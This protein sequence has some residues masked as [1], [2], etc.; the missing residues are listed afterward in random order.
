[1]NGFRVLGPVEALID[2]RRL[3]LGGPRQVA[4]LALLLL[5]ANRAV[6]ADVLI[7]ALWGCERDGAM[8]RLQMAIARLRKALEPL[9][10]DDGSVL[11]TVT[12]GYML[13]VAPGELD[14][15]VFADRVRDG[16]RALAEGNPGRASELLEEAL[17][18]WRGR[19][20]PEVAFEDFAQ[21]DIRRLEELRLSALETRID[22]DLRLGRHGELIAELE[23]LLDQDPTRE[24]LAGQL[25]TALY[26]SGRQADAL[27][28]FQRTR[29][30]LA[31]ELGLEPGPSLKAVQQQVL[32][33]DPALSYPGASGSAARSSD[34]EPSGSPDRS[35]PPLESLNRSNLPAPTSPLVGRAEELSLALELLAAPEVRLLTLWG[36]GGSGKTRLALEVAASAAARYRDGVRIVMLA[37]IADRALMVSE[38]ARVL[39]I[40]PV[41][42]ESLERTL[43]SGLS[44]RELLL[45][46]DNFEHLLAG[47][48]VVAELLANAPSVAVLATSREPLRIRGEHRMDVPPLP[49]DEAAELFLARA[50]A[51]RPDLTVDDEDLAAVD[52]ICAR[53]DGL[54]L[55]LELAAARV[56][57]FAPRRLEARLA[58]RLALA[59]GPRDLP[60]RQRTLAATIDWSYQLLD[61]A[62]RG[63]LARLSP[64][65]GGVRIDSA[66][67]IWGAGA[68][69]GL[70]SLAEKSLLRRREDPDGEPRFW[71]LETVREFVLDR[72]TAEGVAAAAAEQHAEH[73]RALAEQAAPHLHGRVERRWFD[74]LESDIAN[75]R[76][77]LDHLSEY[78]PSAALGMAGHLAWFWVTR[79]YVTEALGRLTETLATAPP[80][81]PARG[82][83]LVHAGR[84]MLTLGDP[85]RARPLLL[86]A[87]STVRRQGD[88]RLTTLA[89]AWL[90]WCSVLLGD[91]TAVA[92]YYEQAIAAGRAAGDDWALA[93]ALNGYSGSAPV[94]ANPQRARSIA[95]EALSLF[96]RVG[97]P[98]GI[99]VT[100]DT[101]AQ[102]ALDEDDLELAETLNR[103]C[104]GAA[105]EIEYR[106]V[107]AGAHML[108]AIISLLRD[109]VD[110]AAAD[111]HTAIQTNSLLPDTEVAAIALAAGATIAQIRQE[112]VRA[113]LLWAASQHLRGAVPEPAAISRLRTRWQPENPVAS[114]D[115]QEID[116]ATIAGTELELEDAL[117]LAAGIAAPPG[118]PPDRASSP[119]TQSAN[120]G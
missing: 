19:P 18:L 112:P 107:I 96:R 57:V 35:A 34:G 120:P 4:L 10:S 45:V 22:A 27:E 98:G 90:G 108:R 111:L 88:F 71:M 40:D 79:G 67:S 92:T 13:S 24:R 82:R 68:A 33:Q 116:S 97:D 26:R 53:L 91:D 94:R 84:V 16:R 23:T 75:L 56:A 93:L 21:A 20:L 46:L 8:K 81:D 73:F 64:F 63:L 110:C 5:N 105:R 48:E 51:L 61:P 77:A 99:A 50:R 43:V 72:A 95:E 66:E 69:E 12:G 7:D 58:E 103:E 15:D 2:E 114:T 74:R 117:A 78:H 29:C 80:D 87:L 42:G 39:E 14:A 38:L 52:R 85:A 104:L 100:A 76:A 83:A 65:I 47:G 109:D 55:A 49:P 118:P 37:P 9:A 25:M 115:Q 28:V 89:L 1:M 54:P 3:S 11:R 36:P 41:S 113:A 102:I 101:V 60:D 32:S 86:D 44:G 59:E 62:E 30:Q 6:S 70:I 17:G 31:D 106:P 119:T